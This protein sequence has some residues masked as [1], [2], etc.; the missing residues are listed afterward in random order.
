MS[1]AAETVL[2]GHQLERPVSAIVHASWTYEAA[3]TEAARR[4]VSR[5]AFIRYADELVLAR[6]FSGNCLHEPARVPDVRPAGRAHPW[7]ETSKSAPVHDGDAVGE[8]SD[9]GE[10]VARIHQAATPWAA[11]RSRTVFEHVRLRGDVLEARGRLVEDDAQQREGHRE[12]HPLLLSTGQLVT[13]RKT[14][15]LGSTTSSSASA[16]RARRSSRKTKPCADSVSS[17][18]VS[19]FSAGFSEEPGSCGTYQTSLPRSC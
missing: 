16:M 18:C 7:V 14:S 6:P 9:H 17:S 3:R 12:R 1:D 4:P 11:H 13:R 19:I 8:R 2:G 15:S 10:V 5:A